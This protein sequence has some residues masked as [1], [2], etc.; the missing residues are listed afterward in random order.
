MIQQQIFTKDFIYE[1]IKDSKFPFWSL[2]LVQGFK[3]TANVM[4]YYGSDFTDEDTDETKIEKSIATLANT[5][6]T[7]PAESVFVIELKNSKQANGSGIVGPFQF[8]NSDKAAQA[9]SAQPSTLGIVPPGYVPE[10]ALKGLEE[11]LNRNFNAKIEA[12]QAEFDRKQR[13]A[14]FARRERELDERE[15]ELKEMKKEYDSSVAK[16]TDVLFGVGK[17][18]VA[19]FFMPQGAAASQQLGAMQGGQGAPS[20]EPD[21][22]GDAVDDIAAF[23]YQNF[24]TDQIKDLKSKIQNGGENLA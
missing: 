23:L 5:I 20:A 16:A 22:K 12:M 21:E 7:F 10:T 14:E 11:S 3:N 1:R 4:Q 8:S 18:I 9:E 24:T 15:K 19:S 17:K 2:G 6:S 13:E